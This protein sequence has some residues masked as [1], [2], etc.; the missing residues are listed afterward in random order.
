MLAINTVQ[1]PISPDE[2]GVTL[3]HEHIIYGAAGWYADNTMAPFDREAIIRASL[4]TMKQLKA[5]K[6]KTFVDAT[7]ND[8]GRDAEL[9]KEVSEKSGI[10]IICATGLY[11]EAE[12]APAY[13]RLR[14]QMGDATNEISELFMT[15]ITKGIGTSGIKAGVIKV[16]TGN[17]RISPYEEMVLKAAARAQKQTKVPI[18]THTEAGTMGLEQADLLISEGG[19]PKRIMVGHSCGSA[20]LKYHLAILE[21]GVYIAF[22]RLGLDV[23]L[24]D[25]LRKACIIGLIGIGYA[26]RIILSHDSVVRMLGRPVQDMIAMILPNWVP[27]HVFNNIIPALREAGVSADKINT[28]MVE[29]PR[30]LFSGQ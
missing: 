13:F 16:A 7:P 21:K 8:T 4:A 11:S 6:V 24:P 25:S 10:N 20:D 29:N 18:I 12:G 15:E 30:R 26:N 14:T 19:D 28:M 2:L 17:G 22:D 3:M 9:L 27:T 23:L 5:H 1:G